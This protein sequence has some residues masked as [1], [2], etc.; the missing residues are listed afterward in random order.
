MAFHID[1]MAAVMLLQRIVWTAN[2]FLGEWNVM[3]YLS[4]RVNYIGFVREILI[5]QGRLIHFLQ[6]TVSHDIHV[7]KTILVGFRLFCIK[8]EIFISAGTR[9]LLSKAV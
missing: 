6:D 5:C 4:S 3:T 9:V 2:E 7:N 8:A 1:F